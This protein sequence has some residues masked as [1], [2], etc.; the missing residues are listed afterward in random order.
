LK[1]VNKRFVGVID[2]LKG[3]LDELD[4]SG[5]GKDNRIGVLSRNLEDANGA[6]VGLE[7]GRDE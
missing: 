6:V 5:K 2:E 7:G 3:G 4:A 1:L